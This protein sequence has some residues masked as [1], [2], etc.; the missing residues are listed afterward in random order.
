MQKQDAKPSV[1][2]GGGWQASLNDDA[3]NKLMST[4][5]GLAK[6]HCSLVLTPGEYQLLHLEKPNVPAN[7]LKQALSWKVKEM[8]DYPIEQATIEVID[9]PADPY[10]TNRQS[11]VYAVV[12]KNEL[13]STHIQRLANVYGSKLEVIDIPEL[14]QRNIAAYLEQEGRGLAMISINDNGCLLTFTSGG[15]LYHAR[16]I[17]IDSKQLSS[18]DSEKKSRVLERLSL[19]IQRSLDSFEREFNYITTNR[20]VLAPFAGRED[21]YDYLKAFLNIKIDR[22][23]LDD[24]FNFE[25]DVD[26]GDLAMQAS[27]FPVLGAALREGKSS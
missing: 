23:D 26:I 8:I 19:E 10:I 2:F 25:N 15:E 18:D 1:I 24:V 9:I 20:L 5:L 6:L 11:N 12:A 4:N 17:D 21:C 3:T 13:L 16:H 7:E 22:F 27:L 14:G